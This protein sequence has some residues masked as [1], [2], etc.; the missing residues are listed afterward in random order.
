MLGRNFGCLLLCALSEL[1]ASTTRVTTLTISCKIT[2]FRCKITSISDFTRDLSPSATSWMFSGVSF[3]PLNAKF[4]R[5]HSIPYGFATLTGSCMHFVT[6]QPASM[7][8]L[9]RSFSS[10]PRALN[11]AL[12]IASDGIIFLFSNKPCVLRKRFLAGQ[13]DKLLRLNNVSLLESSSYHFSSDI[14]VRY[15]YIVY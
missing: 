7:D 11:G 15:F 6:P 1:I 8:S 13:V 10:K 9:T 4:G 14:T 3:T 2:H 5:T 12:N